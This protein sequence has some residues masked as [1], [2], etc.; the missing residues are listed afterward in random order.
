MSTLWEI[1]W[2]ALFVPS[3]S[4]VEIML[5]GSVIYLFL[6]FLMRALHRQ[7]GQFNIADLLVVVIIADAAQNGMA[8][9][10]ASITEG[11]VLIGTIMFWNVGLDWASYRY[12]P[13]R[14]LVLPAPV[15]L[16]RDGR[17]DWRA[18]RRQLIT[19]TELMGRVHQEGLQHLEDVHRCYVEPDG[20]LSVISMEQAQANEAR[21]RQRDAHG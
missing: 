17:I 8:G 18:M 5:R 4:L 11:A 14:R 15:T 7:A 6:F 1:D 10:Y 20:K 21:R 16:V 13:I 3:G 2:H 19:E 12:E 9:S